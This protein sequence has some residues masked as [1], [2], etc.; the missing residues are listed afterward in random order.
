MRFKKEYILIAVVFT[1]MASGCKKWEDHTAINNQ[2]LTQDLYTAIKNDAS[3]SRFAEL[4]TQAGLD[5]LLKSSKNFTVWAPSNNALTTLDPSI[6]N[7]AAKLRSFILNHISYQLYFTRD[8]QTSK[9]IG[10]LNGKYNNFLGNKFEDATITSAD[11]F[12][13]NGV[14]HI[15][16]KYILVLPNLWDHINSTTAQY[17]QNSFIAGLNFS[18]FDPTLAVI[19]SVSSST[20]LPVYHAGTGIVLKN[21]FNERVFDTRR[22]DKQFTYFIIENAGFTL[23]ADSLKPYFN[24]TSIPRTDSLDK[25]NIVKDL[26]VDTLYPSIASLP[27]VLVSK[28]GIAL[29]LNS[30]LI[31]STKKVSN[32]MVYVLSSSGT[33]TASRFQQIRIEGE[34]PAGFSRTDKAGNINYRVRRNPVTNQ[35]F[36]D[37]YVTATNVT[38]TGV[39][40]FYS[41]YTLNEMPSMKYNVYA[42]AVN[43]FQTGAVLQNISAS[44]L[45]SSTP[46]AVYTSLGG[47]AYNVPLSTAAGAYNEV[48]LGQFTSTLYGTLEMRLIQAN[49]TSVATNTPSVLDYLRLVPV[50]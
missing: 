2:D 40:G 38:G 13:K 18:F 22:E 8:A 45:V 1:I 50:P 14:L 4:V 32:G 10:M 49:A 17:T 42:S 27:A 28:F 41:Y 34:N 44:Y 5:T 36:N 48:L 47:L 39:I 9:R 35:Y 19:D 25:W 3:L 37:L 12:V 24:T 21:T 26:V 43:D 33:T 11:K 20:G 29:P 15:V 30:S 16:D 46:A 31:T 6:P 7:D 23:K